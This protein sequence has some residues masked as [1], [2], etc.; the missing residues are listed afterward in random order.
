VDGDG[1]R[2]GH[3]VK[4]T[5]IVNDFALVVPDGDLAFHGVD[6][7]DLADVAVENIFVIIILGLDHFVP[8]AELPAELFHDRLASAGRIQFIL[9]PDVE[10]ADTQRPPVSNRNLAGMRV[11]TITTSVSAICSG[12]AR[13]MK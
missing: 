2:Q 4:F 10:F 11:L 9:E 8:W 1:A 5:K 3:F 12:S 13:S 6:L 7:H